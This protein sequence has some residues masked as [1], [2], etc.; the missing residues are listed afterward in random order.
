MWHNNLPGLA[1]GRV[2]MC[3]LGALQKPIYRY[4][5]FS[6]KAFAFLVFCCLQ[7]LS[8]GS[9]LSLHFCMH[10]LRIAAFLWV[11]SVYSA[12]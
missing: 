2:S 10:A 6:C 7:Y 3:G 4:V 8:I 9:G 11:L 12:L 5:P 1:S